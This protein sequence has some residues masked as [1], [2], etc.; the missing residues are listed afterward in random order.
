MREYD[1]FN[2]EEI[3]LSKV[4]DKGADESTGDAKIDPIMQKNTACISPT[5]VFRK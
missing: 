3:E 5:E 4:S 1:K 2:R